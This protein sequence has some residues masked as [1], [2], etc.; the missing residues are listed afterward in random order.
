MRSYLILLN[1]I[2]YFEWT[3]IKSV[4]FKAIVSVRKA[5]NSIWALTV[6]GRSF[7]AIY[8]Y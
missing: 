4:F 8:V 3:D 6:K 2:D 5:D 7:N 1:I